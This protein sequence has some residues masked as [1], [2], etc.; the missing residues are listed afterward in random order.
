MEERSGDKSGEFRRRRE[1]RLMIGDKRTIADRA[2]AASAQNWAS[3]PVGQW[4]HQ[5]SLRTGED[6]AGADGEARAAPQ[7]DNKL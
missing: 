6:R 7:M 3:I 2:S 5:G 1:C 4:A